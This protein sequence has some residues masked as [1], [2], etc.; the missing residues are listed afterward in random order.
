MRNLADELPEPPDGT[1]LLYIDKI[2]THKAIWR[3]D[4]EAGHGDERW[5]E[6]AR[7]GT[8]VTRSA[9]TRSSSTP[10]PS[11][12]SRTFPS[13]RSETMKAQ[14]RRPKGPVKAANTTT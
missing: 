1:R 14:A 10:R 8:G 9:G 2:G 7:S 6:G 12:A 3:N 13:P 5:Y 4:E 11:M